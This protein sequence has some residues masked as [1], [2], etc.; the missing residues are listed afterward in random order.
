MKI[1][2]I[3]YTYLTDDVHQFVEKGQELNTISFLK[4]QASSSEKPF[5]VNLGGVKRHP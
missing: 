3:W 4:S 5:F 1:A 2:K